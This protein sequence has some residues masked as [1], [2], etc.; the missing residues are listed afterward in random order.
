M[1]L[2]KNALKRFELENSIEDELL[3]RVDEAK[4]QELSFIK[5]PAKDRPW[6]KNPEHFQKVKISAVALIK[7][8]MH[9]RS[10]GDIEV[11]GSL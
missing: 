5:T 7:M 8:S 10:G 4:L 6:K 3:Y 1:E 9:S 11:M 2:T